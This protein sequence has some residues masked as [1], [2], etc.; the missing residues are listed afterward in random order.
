[1]FRLFATAAAAL[2]FAAGSAGAQVPKD[3]ALT[4]IKNEGVMKVC[5]AQVTPDSYKDP[6]T[7]QWTGVFVDITNELADWM[8]VKVEPVEVQWST[9]IL[10]LNRGD[11]DLFGASLLY[12]APR[13]EEID[14]IT[15][16]SAKGMN[17]V[18]AKGNPKHFAK[19]ED[20]NQ[21]GVTLAAVAGSRDQEVAGR[22]FPKAKL[23]AL[24]TPTDIAL[25][26]SV[27]RGDADAAFANGITIRWWL[28]SP[29]A[30]W[31]DIAFK[32]DFSVQPNGWA[33]RYGDPAWKDFLEAFGHWAAANHRAADLYEQY[34]AKS[35][36]F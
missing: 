10:A 9:V 34:L 3:S 6:K 36:L 28:K 11:C 4:R 26:E 7:G 33:I 21:P 29:D 25:F 35:S 24:A 19:P 23:I 18:I 16:F 14:Y 2:L 22:M 15:P 5:Y 30:G 20:F 12:N 31:A 1:M 8:K 27:R 17:A 13:S 32:D